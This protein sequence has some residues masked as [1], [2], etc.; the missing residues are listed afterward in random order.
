MRSMR[1]WAAH[2]SSRGGRPP[3]GAGVSHPFAM[4]RVMGANSGSMII[5]CDT[6]CMRATAT[7]ADCVVTHVL[8]PVAAESVSLDGDEIRVVRLLVKAGMMP[9]LRHSETD[10]V[11]A[12]C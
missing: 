7:C 11:A 8:N 4:M 12:F 6:C 10:A 5:S 2:L 1:L 3:P 9:T